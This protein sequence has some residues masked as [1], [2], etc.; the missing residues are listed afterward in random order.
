MN[1]DNGSENVAQTPSFVHPFPMSHPSR[2]NE[3]IRATSFPRA[4]IDTQRRPRVLLVVPTKL[5]GPT[6]LVSTTARD[7]A[8][9]VSIQT[10]L[11]S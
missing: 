8:E 5:S 7:F 3:G 1:R 4:A 6:G 10:Q 9:P 11:E 2:T